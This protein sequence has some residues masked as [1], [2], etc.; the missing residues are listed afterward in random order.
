LWKLLYQPNN[1]CIKLFVVWLKIF[2]N[3]AKP[4]VLQTISD[5]ELRLRQIDSDIE[6]LNKQLAYLHRVRVQYAA[7]VDEVLKTRGQ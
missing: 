1:A 6:R 4:D 7:L 3:K 2:I 5:N